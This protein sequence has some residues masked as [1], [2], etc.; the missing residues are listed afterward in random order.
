MLRFNSNKS[1]IQLSE[2][3]NTGIQSSPH[4]LCFESSWFEQNLRLQYKNTILAIVI[5]VGFTV[6]CLELL[7]TLILYKTSNRQLGIIRC[8][9]Q[10]VN[11]K[12]FPIS[13]FAFTMSFPIPF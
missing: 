10:T 11:F 7:N 12:F 3:I 1:L 9:Q 4:I 8:M 13:D 5:G 2:T 6:F